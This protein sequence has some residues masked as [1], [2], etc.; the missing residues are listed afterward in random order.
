MQMEFLKL[1]KERENPP[2]ELQSTHLSVCLSVCL[3]I[4]TLR[5][6]RK[7]T[8]PCTYLYSSTTVPYTHTYLPALTD[9]VDFTDEEGYGKYLDLH[10]CYDCFINLK[11]LEVSQPYY[12]WCAPIGVRPD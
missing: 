4:F 10:Q 5:K 9:M 1:D 8:C 12:M 3:S 2:E 6:R 11:Q 7:R